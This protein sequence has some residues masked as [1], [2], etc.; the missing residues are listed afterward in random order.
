M[1]W[2]ERCRIVNGPEAEQRLAAIRESLADEPAPVPDHA[3]MPLKMCSVG[4]AIWMTH[5]WDWNTQSC[6]R[7]SVN[8]PLL[9]NPRE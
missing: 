5:K 8:M 1:N 4:G 2:T 3:V 9:T 6:I 7:C